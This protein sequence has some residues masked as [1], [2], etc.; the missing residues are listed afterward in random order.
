[1]WATSPDYV[2]DVAQILAKRNPRTVLLALSVLEFRF[3]GDWS[4]RRDERA[5]APH[6]R[7]PYD[8]AEPTPCPGRTPVRPGRGEHDTA[9]TPNGAPAAGRRGA[10]QGPLPVDRPDDSHV[11]GRHS[12]LPTA[13]TDRRGRPQ[14][15]RRRG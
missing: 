12:E 7:S 9:R 6:L 15:R 5:I 4:S 1:M 11:D 14:R 2:G 13:D 8:R 10:G 3:A